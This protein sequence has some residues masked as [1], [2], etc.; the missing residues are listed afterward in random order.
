[1]QTLYYLTPGPLSDQVSL[2]PLYP[3]IRISTH[4][5]RLSSNGSYSGKPSLILPPVTTGAHFASLLGPTPRLHRV[6]ATHSRKLPRHTVLPSGSRDQV[7][8]TLRD[9]PL[10]QAQGLAPAGAQLGVAQR[11]ESLL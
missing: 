3:T 8:F 7:L 1:M 9:P 2:F 5:S 10:C 6:K 4:P 11:S